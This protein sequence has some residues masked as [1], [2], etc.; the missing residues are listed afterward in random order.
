METVKQLKCRQCSQHD[1][2]QEDDPWVQMGPNLIV[3]AATEI[4]QFDR[5]C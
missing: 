3:G 1:Q 4:P 2:S 5:F